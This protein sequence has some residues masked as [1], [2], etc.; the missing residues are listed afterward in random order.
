MAKKSKSSNGKPGGMRR[1][2]VILSIAILW[3]AGHQP[4]ALSLTT[5]LVWA[6]GIVT[7]ALGARA[8]FAVG[9][10]LVKLVVT[11]FLS[12]LQRSAPQARGKT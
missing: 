5:V 9:E 1:G 7:V 11:G 4:A 12:L 6:L 10:P 3:A 2:L 8:A